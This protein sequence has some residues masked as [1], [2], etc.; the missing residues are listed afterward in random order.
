MFCRLFVEAAAVAAA[1]AAAVEAPYCF[2]ERLAEV[3]VAV[4][5]LGRCRE[6]ILPQSG[7]HEHQLC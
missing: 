5:T 7:L 2:E 1:S 3:A 6:L 4:A